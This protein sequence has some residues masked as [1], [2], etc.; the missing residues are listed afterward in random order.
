MMRRAIVAA[1]LLDVAIILLT[2]GAYKVTRLGLHTLA[3]QA[4]QARTEHRPAQR[5]LTAVDGYDPIAVYDQADKR[6][7]VTDHAAADLLLCITYGQGAAP[8]C[9]LPAEWVGR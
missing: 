1:L 8:V 9:K 7:T 3:V 5:L 6:L 2:V 4:T